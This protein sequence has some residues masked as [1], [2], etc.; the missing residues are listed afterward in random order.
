MEESFDKLWRS[1]HV[2]YV[3]DFY[4]EAC[5]ICTEPLRLT[6]NGRILLILGNVKLPQAKIY[7][8]KDRSASLYDTE[9]P[10]QNSQVER[11]STRRILPAVSKYSVIYIPCDNSIDILPK[12]SERK[13]ERK[14]K[15]KMSNLT[16]VGK[17]YK[18]LSIENR[19]AKFTSEI[20]THLK[21]SLI[22]GNKFYPLATNNVWS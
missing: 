20:K 15:E 5:S 4:A 17:K 13:A 2:Y 11:V 3:A 22:V 10:M 6:S 14:K 16:G 12:P 1:K 9:S 7:A 8:T 18:A 21:L 19:D